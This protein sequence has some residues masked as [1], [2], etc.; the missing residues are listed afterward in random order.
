MK[1][2]RVGEIVEIEI[3]PRQLGNRSGIGENVAPRFVVQ[4]HGESSRDCARNCAHLRHIHPALLQTFERDL[5]ERIVT[6]AGLK[7]HAAA[8]SGQIMRHNG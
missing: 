3:V 1:M 7:S 8:E 6:D 4:D 5:A 2:T